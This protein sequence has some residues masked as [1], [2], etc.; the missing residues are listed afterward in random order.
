[1]LNKPYAFVSF[2]VNFYVK[3]A[4]LKMTLIEFVEFNK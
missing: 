4:S 2:V 1:M 3:R